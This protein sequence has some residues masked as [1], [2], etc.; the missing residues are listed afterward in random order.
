[1]LMLQLLELAALTEV[2]VARSAHNLALSIYLAVVATTVAL[3][4]AGIALVLVGRYRLGGIL[5]IAA[6]AVH[7]L[8]LEGIIGIVGGLTAIRRARAT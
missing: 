4:I 7:V 5:Q 2:V 1:M 8:K 6:S 3:Q